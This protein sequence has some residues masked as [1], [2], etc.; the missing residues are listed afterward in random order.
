MK[1]HMLTLTGVTVDA[2]ENVYIS[3]CNGSIEV[4][5][6][7]QQLMRS[8]VTGP[9]SSSAPLYVSRACGGGLLYTDGFNPA[10]VV[11][12]DKRDRVVQTYNATDPGAI[13]L[14]ALCD[15]ADRSVWALDG[16]TA[17][18]HIYHFTAD[19]Q[20]A[21]V[22]NYSLPDRSS[23][24]ALEIDQ[25]RHTLLMAYCIEPPHGGGNITNFIA[26]IDTATGKVMDSMRVS[27]VWGIAATPMNHHSDRVYVADLYGHKLAMYRATD[28]AVRVENDTPLWKESRAHEQ[29]ALV[30]M[31]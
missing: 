14:S 3:H 10:T 28:S 4:Y 13:F 20:Q 15:E 9:A 22:M 7:Q 31:K 30:Q 5:N 1:C 6:Q 24:A 17:N 25:I 18:V 23:V 12:M 21:A 16:S 2:E 26:Y 8:V 27:G 11:Q 29:G 19:G